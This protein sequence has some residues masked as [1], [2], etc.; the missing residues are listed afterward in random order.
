MGFEPIKYATYTGDKAKVI[1]VTKQSLRNLRNLW[2]KISVHPAP[3]SAPGTCSR[4]Q[5]RRR[6]VVADCVV[7]AY[8]MAR[9]ATF[10]ALGAAGL[11]EK[12]R[13][14]GV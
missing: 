12:A 10:A 7:S 4:A 11:A 3:L 8:I 6:V 13:L 5:H 14:L 9:A 2:F 1:E